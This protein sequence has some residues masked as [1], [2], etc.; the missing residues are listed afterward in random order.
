L[1]RVETH[2]DGKNPKVKLGMSINLAQANLLH[3]RAK[4]LLSMAGIGTAVMLMF[5]QLGFRGAVENTANLMFGRMEFDCIVR[6][7][8]YLHFVDS[9][10][11]PRTVTDEIA[12]LE[13]V[14]SVKPFHVSLGNWRHPKGMHL[15]GIMIM[16]LDPNQ[17]PFRDRDGSLQAQL[18]QL[19]APESVL[20]DQ[21]SHQEFGPANGTQFSEA[22]I[23][24]STDISGRK[25]T[26]VGLFRMGAGLTANAAVMTSESGFQ[27]F[28][29]RDVQSR[30][31]FGLIRLKP[32]Y[33]AEAFAKELR[34]RFQVTSDQVS[35]QAQKREG[36]I[37]NEESMFGPWLSPV[38][39]SKAAGARRTISSVDVLTRRDVFERERQRWIA[40]TPIGFIFTLGVLISF[41]VGAAIVYMVLATDVA[42]RI[43]E[44]ATLK[45]MGYSNRYLSWVVL[46]Q[47]LYLSFASFVPAVLFSWLFYEVTENLANI[48]IFMTFAR[49]V[50]VFA[51]SVIMSLI[52]GSLAV[53]K[54]WQAQPAELF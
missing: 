36:D 48:P 26:I 14:A 23:G 17:S 4:T 12:G 3:N 42:N 32:G 18:N 46:R 45:A 13:P 30:V 7:P 5:I 37:E 15:R 28:V 19:T 31:S 8:D 54:L 35:D 21:Q 16:G 49:I 39:E 38:D 41:V 11:I 34:E 52:S 22:D 27:R 25:A 40:E 43:G 53:R 47:A 29:P 10:D 50:F 44:Y 20:I 1:I 2:R 9:R 51:L 24:V 6:S 33:S